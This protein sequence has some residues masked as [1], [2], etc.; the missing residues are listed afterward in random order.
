LQS[1]EG[2]AS[3]QKEIVAQA[4]RQKLNSGID[5]PPVGLETER[6]PALTD[7]KFRFRNRLEG[8]GTTGRRPRLARRSDSRQKERNSYNMAGKE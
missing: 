1:Q 6:K 2:A 8:V 4:A 3:G 7:R 5:L